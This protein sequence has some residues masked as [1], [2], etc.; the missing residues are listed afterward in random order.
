MAKQP[1]LTPFWYTPEGQDEGEKVSFLLRPLTQPQMVEVEEHYVDG[2]QTA[3]AQYVAGRLGI[4]QVRGVTHP[5]TGEP[6][7]VPSCFEWLSRSWVKLCGTR[8]IAEDAGLDWDEIMKSLEPGEPP[9][10]PPKPEDDPEG[11]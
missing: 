9:A 2:K 6:A 7:V 1:K 11:N 8:L 10:G 5:E 4:I 3:K